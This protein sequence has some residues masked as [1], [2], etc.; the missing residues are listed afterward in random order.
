MKSSLGVF[1]RYLILVIF[2]LFSN[3]VSYARWST[4]EDAAI[5]FKYYN[6]DN[7]IHKD[8]TCESIVEIRQKILKENARS[9]LAEY[10]LFYNSNSS[11]INIIE[12]KTIYNDKEYIVTKSMIE[13][14]PVASN[15]SGFDQTRQIKISFPK[16]E[17]NSEI[18][19]KYSYKETKPILKNFYGT[20]FFF[21]TEGYLNEANINIKSELPLN[22][23]VNDPTNILKI[24]DNKDKK[25]NQ[26][27][28]ISLIK[29]YF[30]QISNE[31]QDGILNPKN[32]SFVTFSSVTDFKELANKMSYRYDS[33]MNQKLPKIFEQIVQD[34]LKIDNEIDQIN[35][36]TSKLNEKIQYFGDWRSIDGQM[37]PHNLE[38]IATAQ[39]GDCKDFSVSVG[40]IL[41]TLGYKVDVALIK[42]GIGII[43]VQDSLPVLE[44]FNHAFL[45]IIGK[46]DK[47]Y[48]IDPT[49]VIS[50][51]GD[52]FP[53]VANKQV[54][55]LNISNPTYEITPDI[56]SNKSKQV[57]NIH[58]DISNDKINML[59]DLQIIGQSAS[60]FTGA[61]L[62]MSDRA[63]RD[64][65]FQIL[66]GTDLPED[67][68]KS[69]KITD[70]SSRIVNDINAEF[71]FFQDNLLVRTTL[72]DAFKLPYILNN[73]VDV[74]QD[75]ISDLFVGV[76]YSAISTRIIKN[77]KIENIKSLNYEKDTPW[78]YIKRVAKHK[79]SDTEIYA[80][81][82][83]KKSFIRAEELRTMEY[84]ELKKD[85][86][87]K[88]TDT[89]VILKK[90]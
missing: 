58:M 37:F 21:G 45:K 3:L 18:Y 17:L 41:K 67:H 69:L 60:Y 2:I 90:Q 7:I 84:K 89:L 76:P 31:P 19:L 10:S 72:G 74:S 22:I 61:K 27:I 64:A 55:V 42:R 52:I 11:K 12:A 34:A 50:M 48:W 25:N 46:N 8:G 16:I 80:E 86:E 53:D 33:V 1:M 6:S 82:K 13:D 56:D 44:A 43:E 28:N 57:K 35:F 38:N 23:K 71:E 4:Y 49:N 47:I 78:I 73:F 30:A 9:L 77:I 68:K 75:Q 79:V 15:N 54:L 70:L 65:I 40:A 39:L 88:F 20:R 36:V 83:L 32:L 66:S 5:E 81:I 62:Y 29:P 26:I 14:K 63:I 24:V 51:A 59:G 85:I 87:K